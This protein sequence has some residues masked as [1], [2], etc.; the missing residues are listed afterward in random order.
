MM[1]G[2]D[3]C[4]RLM[5]IMNVVSKYYSKATSE[6]I[7]VTLIWLVLMMMAMMMMMIIV[8]EINVQKIFFLLVLQFAFFVIRPNI[9]HLQNPRAFC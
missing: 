6:I 4:V 5:I 7:G 8:I 3:G 9:F 2:K 1:S